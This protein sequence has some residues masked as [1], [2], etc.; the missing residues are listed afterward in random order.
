MD[1]PLSWIRAQYPALAESST[2]FLDNAAGAQ[3]PKQVIQGVSDTLIYR[4]ANKGGAFKQ[5]QEITALK[6]GVREK[7]AAFINA[8][9]ARNIVFGPNATTL[10]E[11]LSISFRQLIRPGDEVVVTELDHHANVDPWRRLEGEGAT[12]KVWR[13]RGEEAGLIL[14]DLEALLSPKTKLL[15]MTAAS[16]ALGTLT[17]VKAAA[18]RVH[19]VGGSMMVDAVHYAP[20]LMPDVA[21]MG[22]DLLVFSPYKVFGPH[23]GVLYLSDRALELLP[24]PK[25]SFLPDG[26]PVAWEPG[27]QN[28]EGIMGFGGVLDYLTALGERLGLHGEERTLWQGVYDAFSLHERELSARLLTGLEDLGAQVY[29]LKHSQGRTATVSFNLPG[30]HAKAVAESLAAQDIAVAYGHYYAYALMMKRLGLEPQGGAVRASAL[31]YN[32]SAEIERFLEAL[33][34]L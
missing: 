29:G 26:D 20:H 17:D 31:H 34:S 23:L 7:V 18:E 13:T 10:I 4:N 24:A 16:N 5:S 6:E 21:A 3:V 27:T 8:P 12:H 32:D 33:A 1:Y 9:A 30:R 15:A 25:L 2:V 19:A 22:A 14:D 11:L 28:H